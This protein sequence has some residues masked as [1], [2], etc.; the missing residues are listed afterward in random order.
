MEEPRTRATS[1]FFA[2]L[3][4]IRSGPSGT[5]PPNRTPSFFSRPPHSSCR[6]NGTIS[7]PI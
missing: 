2:S 7:F 1:A 6:D 3:V 5:I 4:A